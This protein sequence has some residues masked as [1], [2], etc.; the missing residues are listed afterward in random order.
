MK[1]YSLLKENNGHEIQRFVRRDMGKFYTIAFNDIMV[2]YGYNK[3]TQIHSKWYF[4]DFV[5]MNRRI[6]L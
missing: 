6:I 3:N 2:L 1:E 4:V 5:S